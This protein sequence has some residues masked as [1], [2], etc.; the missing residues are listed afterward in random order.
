MT[1]RYRVKRRLAR[2]GMAEV[3]LAD[4]LG[5]GGFA[6]AVAL[7]RVLPHL[8]GD[9]RVVRMFLAEAKLATHLHHPN[10]VQVFDVGQGPEG[11]FIAME[12][13][14]GW[15]LADIAQTTGEI[16]AEFPPPLA[17]FVATE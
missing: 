14:D 6:K 8:A 11:L 2:G 9:A 4:A 10:V 3:Y 13:V 5:A 1:E 17:A 16:G 12:W 15:D 7:K